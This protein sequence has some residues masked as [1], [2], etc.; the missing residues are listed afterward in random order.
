VPPYIPPAGVTPAGAFVPQLFD[1]P[2]RPPGILADAIDP[3]TGEYL[4]ILKGI[5]PIDAQVL[6][7][8]KIK[9]GSGAAVRNDGQRFADIKKVDDAAA[10]LI[11]GE[12]RRA[13]ARLSEN[14][15][16]RVISVDAVADQN[17]D[18]ADVV[19]QFKNLR[20]RPKDLRAAR[21]TP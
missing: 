18:Y 1:D 17:H 2:G 11:D 20:A 8:M 10:S 7:A 9:R 21:V 5:D 16:I 6:D 12:A 19:V 3:H 4:S 15:D 14:Q 13:L